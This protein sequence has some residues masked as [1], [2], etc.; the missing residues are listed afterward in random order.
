MKDKFAEYFKHRQEDLSEYVHMNHRLIITKMLSEMR[1][2]L[3]IEPDLQNKDGYV[4]LMVS[5]QV[6]LLNECIYALVG[7]C[8]AFKLKFTDIIPI[9]TI[10][11]LFRLIEGKTTVNADT[12]HLLPKIPKEK[13]EEYYLSNIEDLRKVIQEL[14]K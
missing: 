9:T 2:K 6:R 7:Y 11:L 14:P 4:S 13:M 10:E 1:R 5:L 12:L 8:E 3:E